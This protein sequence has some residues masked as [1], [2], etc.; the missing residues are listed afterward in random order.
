MAKILVTGAGGFIGFNL[1]HYFAA[2]GR[3]V[4]GVDV[5]FPERRSSYQNG[6]FQ[7]VVGD[8]RDWDSM[9]VMLEGVKVV[10]HLAAAHL[11]I[12]MDKKEYWD[13]NV[14]S[15]WPLLE[16]A[17][18]KGVQRFVHVS[19]VGVYGKLNQL[20]ANEDS[21]CNPQSIYGKTKLAGEAEVLKFHNET[22]F[23]IVVLRPAWVYGPHCPRT[24]KLCKALD[25]GKFFKIGRCENFRHPIY[26]TDMIDACIQ[27]MVSES[28]VGK[29]FIIA[30]QK[31]VTTKELV[32]GFCDVLNF[33]KPRLQIPYW[34][35]FVLASIIER[36]AKILNKEPPISRRTL[37]FFNTNNAFDTKK[38]DE[39]LDF[40]AQ[41]AFEAGIE[42]CKPW[43]LK[44]I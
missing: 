14:N 20:P 29:T 1:A 28:A 22:G 2:Q 25:K 34:S 9:K 27:A 21:R 13:I 7:E 16:L 11:Q 8:F 31:A 23:Q 12:S 10:F 4:I 6:R 43:I 42:D 39:I 18:Q 44:N 3:E 19:S 26:I 35:G 41:F 33:N 38:A 37:E 32:N 24:L 15:L 40:R 36:I 5:R 30:G 17:S